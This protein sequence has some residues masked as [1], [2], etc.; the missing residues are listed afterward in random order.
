[1]ICL[2]ANVWDLFVLKYYLLFYLKLK[3]N[4]ASYIL[5][6]NP[7]LG[8]QCRT[9]EFSSRPVQLK[10]ELRLGLKA[11]MVTVAEKA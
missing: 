11:D 2:S 3:F 1:M 7:N 5:S 8:E 4:W 9:V 6:G 10:G